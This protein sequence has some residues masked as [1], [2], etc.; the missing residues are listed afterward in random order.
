M[1]KQLHKLHSHCTVLR[2]RQTPRF[3]DKLCARLAQVPV[4]QRLTAGALP[5]RRG[6]RRT[7]RPV[8]F[9]GYFGSGKSTVA[10]HLREL[11]TDYIAA[12]DQEY[13]HTLWF[14][15][16]YPW[17]HSEASI[18]PLWYE[19]QTYLITAYSRFLRNQPQYLQSAFR[20]LATLRNR[21]WVLSDSGRT[22]WLIPAIRRVFPDALFV[23]IAHDGPPVI[24]RYAKRVHAQ[25][26]RYYRYRAHGYHSLSLEELLVRCAQLWVL[27]LRCSGILQPE[28]DW[29]PA[30]LAAP[31]EP[32]G[33]ITVR[34]EDYLQNPRKALQTIVDFCRIPQR[35]SPAEVGPPRQRK[36]TRPSVPHEIRAEL[37]PLLSEGLA[38]L[39]YPH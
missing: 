8:L 5:F 22:L 19:P 17:H 11:C 33:I 13:N 29:L 15:G 7:M 23:H 4:M 1:N 25:L 34:F 10:A 24:Y 26:R 6:S 35:L 27:G 20:T 32:T 38:R 28:P 16:L 21:S 2:M 3:A 31:S 37:D 18:P 9:V 39:G 30:G 36:R 14:P 12:F